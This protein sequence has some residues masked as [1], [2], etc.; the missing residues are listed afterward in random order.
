MDKDNNKQ[1]NDSEDLF[2]NKHEPDD[3]TSIVSGLGMGTLKT[4]VFL[5]I[6]FILISSDVFIDR[7]LSSP[8][9]KYAEGRH[10]TE[11]GTVVQGV[12]LSLG[13]IF[14]HTLIT[15]NYI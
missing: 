5:F 14:I 2:N 13:Y 11:R 3:V 4:S 7:I 8:D 1:Q 6:I 15:C 9:N 12:I 10:C